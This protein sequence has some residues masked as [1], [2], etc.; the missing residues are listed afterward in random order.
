MTVFYNDL[1]A[2]TGGTGTP[3]RKPL[4]QHVSDSG[5]GYV[6]GTVDTPKV[7]NGDQILDA[8]SAGNA[9]QFWRSNAEPPS[10]DYKSSL[11]VTTLTTVDFTLCGPGVRVQGAGANTG[12]F[13][14]IDPNED[15]LRLVKYVD[16]VETYLGSPFTL[17][18]GTLPETHKVSVSAEGTTIKAYLDDVERISVTDSSITG[19]GNPG[20]VIR[21][22]ANFA[23]FSADNASAESLG[24]S[25]TL[26]T[27]LQPGA[28]FTLNY[29]NYDAVPVSPVTITD[30]NNN[31]ITVPVTINNTV[32]GGKHGGTATGTFPALPSSG[33]ATGLLFGNVTVGLNT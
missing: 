11:D 20:G 13:A 10:A 4:D 27:D 19:A 18:L 8:S 21:I 7:N 30:S 24:A 6:L 32:T 5:H 15:Q 16:G 3:P 22:T 28:S 26:G 23:D 31:S 17:N 9:R 14:I 2:G 25:V 33:T 12:Y 29:S 1:F